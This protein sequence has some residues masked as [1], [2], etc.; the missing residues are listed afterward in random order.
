SESNG[1]GAPSFRVQA[2]DP[3]R[4]LAQRAGGNGPDIENAAPGFCAGGRLLVVV[5]F[6][7]GRSG[8]KNVAPPVP[9]LAHMAET[10]ADVAFAVVV[11]IEA[12]ACV[13]EKER[14]LVLGK[15]HEG[16]G[17]VDIALVAELGLDIDRRA[18][19]GLRLFGGREQRGAKH[20]CS[21]N[22]TP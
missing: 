1:G 5:F 20:A 15:R 11:A 13:S 16:I 7:G 21:D 8:G 9:P 22:E 19:L 6:L 4:R 2:V 18:P 3:P 10:E 12:I 14:A 17:F